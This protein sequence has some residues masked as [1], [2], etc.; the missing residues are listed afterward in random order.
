MARP[1]SRHTGKQACS[2]KQA[3]VSA[4]HAGSE[5]MNVATFNDSTRTFHRGEKGKI[6]L[7]KVDGQQWVGSAELRR[8]EMITADDSDSNDVS[9]PIRGFFC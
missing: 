5:G 7:I 1:P 8:A 4:K 6:T 3:I 2:R 9:G